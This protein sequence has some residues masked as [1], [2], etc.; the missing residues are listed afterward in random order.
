[1]LVTGVPLNS[2]WQSWAYCAKIPIVVMLYEM[3][4]EWFALS[5]HWS[6]LFQWFAIA[7]QRS[8]LRR[9][10]SKIC[11]VLLMDAKIWMTSLII[12]FAVRP[13]CVQD[14]LFKMPSES[15]AAEVEIIHAYWYG[16]KRVWSY[17]LMLMNHA[18]VPTFKQEP[19]HDSLTL[20]YIYIYFVFGSYCEV[21][22]SKER[23]TFHVFLKQLHT[24]SLKWSG[25]GLY[26]KKAIISYWPKM[27]K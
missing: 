13:T 5:T 10:I 6:S 1:M 26:G 9:P 4:I 12:M 7:A 20:I 17:E 18:V 2:I 19:Q 8:R 23:Y 27:W 16:L 24:G 25:S 15:P 14:S 22:C 11:M 21:K 3:M